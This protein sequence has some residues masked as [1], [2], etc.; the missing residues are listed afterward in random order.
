VAERESTEPMF[1]ST[2][3]IGVALYALLMTFLQSHYIT[4]QL[5]PN[6]EYFFGIWYGASNTQLMTG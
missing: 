4:A 1:R 6:S 5:Y 3:K 2:R